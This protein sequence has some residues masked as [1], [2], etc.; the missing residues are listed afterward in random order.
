MYIYIYI[1]MYAYMYLYIYLYIYIFVPLS[2]RTT[3]SIIRGVHLLTRE[4][5][6]SMDFS[7]ISRVSF[8]KLFRLPPLLPVLILFL[9]LAGR[10]LLT[11]GR[12]TI[13]SYIISFNSLIFGR[14]TRIDYSF[15]NIC[16]YCNFCILS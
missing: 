1:Y 16:S 13:F 5:L 10:F 2:S 7:K 15:S 6:F 11:A 8:L 12:Y 4:S 3:G 9:L 14:F